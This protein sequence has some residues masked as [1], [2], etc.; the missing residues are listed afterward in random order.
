M[1]ELGVIS[2]LKDSSLKKEEIR[3]FLKILGL[4]IFNKLLFVCFV[5]RIFY[6]VE[7]I[8]ENLRIVEKSEEYLF[9]LG[10]F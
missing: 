2:L 1:S 6:G 3:L 5:S 10:F 7:I 9:N 8:D 4:N